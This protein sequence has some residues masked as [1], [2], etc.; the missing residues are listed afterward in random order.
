MDPR[1]AARKT[2]EPEANPLSM[3]KVQRTSEIA[4][5]ISSGNTSS[6]MDEIL[7]S[8][9]G[10]VQAIVTPLMRSRSKSSGDP[11]SSQWKHLMSRLTLGT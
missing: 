2:I 6:K 7:N 3:L 11:N 9:C 10:E 8:E 5:D 4:V 1:G